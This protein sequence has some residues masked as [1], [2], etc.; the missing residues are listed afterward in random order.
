MAE[1]VR[2]HCKKDFWGLSGSVK[3]EIEEP[4]ALKGRV[5]GKL[6][7][8][9]ASWVSPDRIL[10][11]PEEYAT[12]V[13][14]SVGDEI[15]REVARHALSDGQ[16][17][18][19]FVSSHPTSLRDVLTVPWEFL[20]RMPAHSFMATVGVVRL[21]YPDAPPA[22][23]TAI[24]KLRCVALWADPHRNIGELQGHLKGLANAALDR[25]YQMEV[26]I[27]CFESPDQVAHACLGFDAHVVYFIGHGGRSA[28]DVRLLIG[29]GG[30]PAEIGMPAFAD[31]LERVGNPRLV[32]LNA[33]ESF[34]GAED[35]P[36]LGA[37]L[38]LGTRVE[39]LISM[40]MKEPIPA[41]TAFAEQVLTGVARG[42]PLAEV[43]HLARGSM[44]AKSDKSFPVTPYIPVLTQRTR[45]AHLFEVSTANQDRELLRL[46]LA[47]R[48]ENAPR[49]P[50]AIESQLRA[51]LGTSAAH[52]TMV[53]GPA[54]CGKST[55]VRGV[56]SDLLTPPEID[57]GRRYLY[58]SAR[59]LTFLD[60]RD[61]QIVQLIQA[62]AREF[63]TFTQSLAA[64]ALEGG[65]YDTIASFV[66]WLRRSEDVGHSFRVVF[67]DLPEQIATDVAVIA[68]AI[69][70]GGSVMVVSR[71]HA[72]GQGA[73]PQILSMG[74]MTFDEIVGL[75]E[76]RDEAQRIF[77]ETNGIPLLVAAARSGVT[78][79][80]VAS[81]ADIVPPPLRAG[82][83]YL[84]AASR[85]IDRE[86]AAELRAAPLEGLAAASV[87]VRQTEDGALT[88]PLG[89]REALV[90]KIDRDTEQTVREALA[91]AHEKVGERDA[92]GGFRRARV[93]SLLRE[94]LEQRLS[95]MEILD[96]PNKR[97]RNFALLLQNAFDLDYR[98]I[99][100]GDEPF[101]ALAMWTRVRSA[102]AQAGFAEDREI[103]AR[104]ARCLVR[105][106]RVD[107]GERLFEE[108]AMEEDD[109]LLQVSILLDWADTLKTKGDPG[110]LDRRIGALTRAQAIVDSLRPVGDEMNLDRLEG[111]IA[112]SLGNALGYGAHARLEDAAASLDRAIRLFEKHQDWRSE[113]AYF[114]KIEIARY[115]EQ[116]P[117][118]LRAEASARMAKAVQHLLART[119]REEAIR[120]LYELGRLG[121][122]AE[123]RAHWFKE[124]YQRSV[125]AYLPIGIHAGIRWKCAELDLHADTRTAHELAALCGQLERWT[126][127]AWSRRVLRNA[128]IRLTQFF[129]SS[130][131]AEAAEFRQKAQRIVDL[132]QVHGEGRGD[133]KARETVARLVP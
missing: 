1:D 129:A 125:H 43:V 10:G 54:K 80:E 71:S 101:D 104:Y 98:Y 130:D 7:A 78:A 17:T 121:S 68:S 6:R 66:A 64:S 124:A 53:V 32:L 113:R 70:S 93:I 5:G 91:D 9:P 39:A 22:P 4:P 123:E 33:C 8:A 103:D 74:P 115:N 63:P 30:Q 102:A 31:L 18:R 60:D 69:I 38:R 84:V 96:E 86:V 108:L 127:N 122:T 51:R 23:R 14:Q 50:R 114:E 13:R 29:A 40:Q 111:N 85:P 15:V 11:D 116:L 16:F 75:F 28:G 90:A 76:S 133:E 65:R 46:K 109:D 59:E 97:E 72:L 34:T 42:M 105:T 24:P 27:L 41:A 107:Q 49:L 37:A 83:D 79:N 131:P 126:E 110:S 56:V 58:F 67:D 128:Y 62:F 73:A 3:V 26:K 77:D 118:N 92:I 45:S 47:A 44:A 36:Y 100:D 2:L 48:L 61:G 57:V 94:A 12:W 19:I 35:E 87:L 89:A 120:W 99:E 95:L 25:T 119:T 117:E 88:I 112:Q 106:G 55:S 52:V 82:L 21:L 132:I 81:L 20:E